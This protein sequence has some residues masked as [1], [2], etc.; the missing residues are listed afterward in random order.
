MSGRVWVG[1]LFLATV[2][3]GCGQ[4]QGGPCDSEDDCA[5]GYFC[6]PDQ[7]MPFPPENIAALWRAAETYGHYPLD[8][9]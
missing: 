4:E 8:P 1:L 3:V 6:G 5:D 7:G 2:A 9:P